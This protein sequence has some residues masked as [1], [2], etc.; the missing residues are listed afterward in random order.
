MMAYSISF[1]DTDEYCEYVLSEKWL[2]ELAKA[3]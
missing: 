3:N 1:M 2:D